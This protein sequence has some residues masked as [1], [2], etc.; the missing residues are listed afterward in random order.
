MMGEKEARSVL[1]KALACSPAD[2]T[3]ALL[4]IQD[5]GLTR[6]AN[7][8]VHQNVAQRNAELRVRAVVGKR[9]AVASTN[10]LSE[11]QVER[12]AQSAFA[13]ARLQA[14]NPDFLSL[15][16]PRPRPARRRGR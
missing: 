4:L 3:E 12:I 7:S 13:V 5:S 16:S 2:Q 15:P 8:A 9:V 6:F 11:P 10:D 14:E 1:E